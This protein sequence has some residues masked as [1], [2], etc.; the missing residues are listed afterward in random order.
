M[1]EEQGDSVRTIGLVHKGK[2]AEEF[3]QDDVLG[4]VDLTRR[5]LWTDIEQV[6]SIRTGDVNSSVGLRFEFWRKSL[7]L[8]AEAPVIG[9]GTGTIP[10]L[11]RRGETNPLVTTTNPHSQILAVAIELGI[12]GTAVLLA[13]WIAHLALFRDGLVRGAGTLTAWFGLVVVI[14]N[15]VSSVFNSHLFDFSQ[16]WLYVFGV[17]I[18]GGMVLHG[19]ADAAS[20]A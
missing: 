5:R 3:V 6:E 1:E 12:V 19:S 18:T 2:I 11:F 7:S 14:Y 8:V 20:K 10:Q 13:M 15:V 17:G 4:I 9:H 16:G